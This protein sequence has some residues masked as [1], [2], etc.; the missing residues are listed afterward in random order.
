[1]SDRMLSILIGIIL[2]LML[3]LLITAGVYVLTPDYT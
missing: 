1:M 3:G 2:G